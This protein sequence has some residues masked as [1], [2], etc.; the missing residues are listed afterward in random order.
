MRTIEDCLERLD[1]ILMSYPV[2]TPPGYVHPT[3]IVSQWDQKFISDVST[4]T[5]QGS[6]LST[7]QSTVVLKVLQKHVN[8]FNASHATQVQQ[9]LQTPVYRR[10]LFESLNF[11][12]E[13]R[14]AGGG[15]LL[16]RFKF[17]AQITADLR[18][19][20]CSLPELSPPQLIH[21]YKIWKVNVDNANHK[22][23]MN[24]IK[25]HN[26]EFDDEVLEFFMNVTNNL[27][28]PTSYRIT[29]D[30]IQI[31]VNNDILTTI[32]LDEM[33]WLKYV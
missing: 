22:E 12:R 5:R 19:L 1:T 23:V 15:T 13:V 17:N 11:P 21:Q 33:E 9:L 28:T 4:H 29:D 16:F 6:S 3:V 8:L 14:W 10:P 32:W 31:D 26:F 27:D 7:A 25:R 2:V 24:I 20:N 30:E 18:N